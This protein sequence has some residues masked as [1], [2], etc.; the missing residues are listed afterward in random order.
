MLQDA[1]IWKKFLE[2]DLIPK[3]N[4]SELYFEEPDVEAFVGRLENQILRL[5]SLADY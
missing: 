2:K 4:M 1:K 5:N 3:N